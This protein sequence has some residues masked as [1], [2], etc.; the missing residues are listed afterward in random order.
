MLS[1]VEPERPVNSLLVHAKNKPATQTLR[2]SSKT[3][4]T[5]FSRCVK[6][7]KHN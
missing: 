2:N 1:R 5:D 4:K 6:V 3:V 7:Q